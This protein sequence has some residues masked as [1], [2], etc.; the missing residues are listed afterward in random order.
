MTTLTRR[1]FLKVSGVTAASIAAAAGT[2]SLLGQAGVSIARERAVAAAP[3][4]EHWVRTTCGMCPSGCG[5]EVRVVAGRAVKVEGNPMHPV[6]QGVCCLRGQA[7][8]EALYS[9]ERIQRPRIQTGEKGSGDWQE[10]SWDDALAI[11]AQAMSSLAAA[12]QAHTI[13]FLHGDTRGS[14]RALIKQFMQAYGSSNTVALESAGEHAARNAVFLSQG[15]NGYPIYDLNNAAYVMAF[16]GNPLESDRYVIGALAALAFM[17]RGRPQRGKFVAIHPRLSLSGVKADEWVPIRPGA[18]GALA[19]GMANVIINS[20]LYDES[21]VRDFTFG[22]DDFEDT[23]G[24]GSTWRMGF[25][26]HV[27]EQ[28]TLERVEMMTGV[29]ASTV[30]RLAGEF[31]SNRPAVAMIPVEA[32]GVSLEDALAVHALNALVG[33]IDCQGGVLTQRFPTFAA[34]PVPGRSL[35]EAPRIDATA[36]P[37]APLTGNTLA[38]RL[39]GEDPYPVNALFL[40]NANPV[41]SSPAGGRMAEALL[42]VPFVVSFASTLDE[43]AAHADLILPASTFLETWGDDFMEGA[44]YSGLSLRQPVV[45]PVHDTRDPGDVLLA[46]AKS[47]GGALSQALPYASYKE[48]IERRMSPLD[49]DAAKYAENGFWAELVYF[50]AEPG[51]KAWSQVVGRDRLNAVQDGRFDFYSRERF[52]VRPNDL[53][54]DAIDLACLPHWTAPDY[55]SQ[56][57][58]GSGAESPA[59]PDADTTAEYPFLLV[60]QGLITHSRNWQGILPTLQESYGLQ[61]NEKWTSWVEINPRAAKPLGLKSGDLVWVESTAGKVRAV[62]RLYEGIW[63]NAIY[64]PPGQGHRTLTRWGFGSP[65]NTVVGANVNQLVTENVATRVK[66]FKA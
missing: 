27:L 11:V 50:N 33:S 7:S 20:K 58:Q 36:D 1:T 12:N 43:S 19:L 16:G 60:S 23:G 24:G 48:L 15:I 13:A 61:S 49:I 29:P 14:M 53:P 18:Y 59:A 6:N 28:Y 41:Y 44:G 56:Y 65:A 37:F 54:A 40:Y 21:F 5:L 46:L 55:S 45:E 26:R 62:V 42:K 35:P 38:A 63:P 30:A 32:D 17:R 8:L 57:P 10:L 4:E 39:L 47:L 51:S 25:K 64:L 52:A 31:A 66:V 3:L 22:F 2:R 34:F 9:P